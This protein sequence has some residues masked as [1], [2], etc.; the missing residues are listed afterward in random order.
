MYF[1]D[2]DAAAPKHSHEYNQCVWGDGR[3]IA[4]WFSDGIRCSFMVSWKMLPRVKLR[5]SLQETAH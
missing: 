3:V 5:D 4:G 1:G 2:P